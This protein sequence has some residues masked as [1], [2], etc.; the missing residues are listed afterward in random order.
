MLRLALEFVRWWFGLTYVI[1][2]PAGMV[3][4]LVVLPQGDAGGVYLFI[5]GFET[6]IIGWLIHPWGRQRGMQADAASKPPRSW[7]PQWSL[8]RPA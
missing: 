5:G 3:W 8:R 4:G 6:L 1:G 7:L 2:G